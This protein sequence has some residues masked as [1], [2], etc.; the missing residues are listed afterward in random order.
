SK[1]DGVVCLGP[2]SEEHKFGLLAAADVLVNPSPLES[3]SLVVL[4]AWLAGTA[5]LVNGWCDPTRD[6][7]VQSGGGL[8]YRNFLE[9]EVALN[10]LLDDTELRARLARAGKSYTT[11]YYSWPAVRRRYFSLLSLVKQSA[12]GNSV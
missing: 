1:R 2:V 10:R 9:F 3:F 11:K 12:I 6:H 5:V 7:C 4:E 8:W